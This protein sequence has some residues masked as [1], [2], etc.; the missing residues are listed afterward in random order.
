MTTRVAFSSFAMILGLALA[1]C[2]GDPAAPAADPS[3]ARD[4][5]AGQ[6]V[7]FAG[8]YGNHAWRGIPYAEPPVGELRWRAPRPLPPWADTRG[9]LATGPS[10][11]QLA[12]VFSGGTRDDTGKP[13][14]Q[15]DCLYLDVFAPRFEPGAV[16]T[17]EASLP[18]M[19]WIHGGGN[20]IGNAGFYDGG[21][22]AA[23]HDVIVVA[24]NY[25][26]GP[27]GWFRHASM[28][29]EGTT[30]ADRSGNYGTL[31]M[32]RALEWVRENI[33][34]FGGDPGNVTIFGE[35]AGG[36]NVMSLVLSA[37][38][39]G[40]FHRAIVQSGGLGSSA[41]WEA[42]NFG[43]EPRG[44]DLHSSNEILVKMLVEDGTVADR[45]AARAW[46]ET[47]D[48]PEI[49][50]YL[51]A[52]THLEILDAY[53]KKGEG[54]SDGMLDVPAVI[55]DGFVLP[56][57]E[58]AGR[59]A[60]G[61]YN[62]V[63]IVFGTNRDEEKLF[64][65]F[66]PHYVDFRLGVLPVPKDQDRYDAESDAR[67]RAWKARS[68]DA[69]AERR[70]RPCWRSRGPACSPTA[71]TG[72]RSPGSPSWP[73]ARPPWAR[74]TAWKSPSCSATGTWARSRTGCSCPGTAAGA[75]PWPSR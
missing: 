13:S 69:P 27:F 29:G 21:N 9:A 5:R 62:Q 42:E 59:I 16:P 74:V 56:R 64:M 7:G 44:G 75:R 15:E 40:L 39:N 61:A 10:C 37:R 20:T 34:G 30:A 23:T 52:K 8:Q 12:S 68:V 22:L 19:F 36:T 45:A 18:V 60:R 57:Q 58:M 55:R 70:R 32:I 49:E 51:R 73:T 25:R 48:D 28:R 11:T 66:N 71:G 46:L 3:S 65:A 63:P 38:A 67:A 31:D 17:G 14:G 43:D 24:I 41:T 26:L 35:S 4:L 6:V 1:A 54:Y 53:I 33:A 47:R 50:S 2:G 72:T